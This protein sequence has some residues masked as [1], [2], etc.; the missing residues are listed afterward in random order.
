MPHVVR[1]MIILCYNL[2]ETS[3]LDLLLDN[4]KEYELM[5]CL[6]REAINEDK[7]C[8]LILEIYPEGKASF[9]FKA[10]FHPHPEIHVH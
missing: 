2:L 10:I 5:L 7:N 1:R 9:C 3:K 6:D 8:L 4:A